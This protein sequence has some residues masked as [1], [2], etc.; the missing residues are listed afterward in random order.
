[1]ART[2]KNKAT[3]YH[4]GLLKARLARLRSSLIDSEKSKGPTTESFETRK[5]GD[6][7]VALVGFPSVGK[8]TLLNKLT[9]T[10]SETASYE[11]TT[12]TCI[13]GV[14]QYNGSN[15]QLLDLPGIIEGASQG[16]GR[17]KQVIATARTA[18]LIL[19]MVDASKGEVHKKLL[20]KELEECGIR[21]NK[22]V[23]HITFKA[24]KTGGLQY[25]AMV[26]QS[27]LSEKL[28]KDILYEQK[29]HNAEVVLRYDATIDDFIDVV[30][31][32]RQYIKCVYVYN[33]IDTISIEE[34]D[35]IA[36]DPY[37]VVLSCEWDLNYDYL[38]A[39]IWEGLDLLRIYTKKRGQQPD[40][41]E[42]IIC[43]NGST[44]ESI[45]NMIHKDMAKNMKYSFVWGKSTKHSPQ[46]V[47]LNHKLSD[48]DVVQIIATVV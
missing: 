48:E 23:P 7:R 36:K 14:I 5:S 27:Q 21:V 2:Q 34:V 16:K 10:K 43:R 29:I 18:D 30:E 47:G 12:L 9:G 33:K 20:E 37:N 32:N 11:F 40:F 19:M 46:R 35:E 17:G 3:E 8:S 38:L 24:K 4:I 39:K 42:P 45:C 26:K 6:A 41:T 25:T 44:I 1:M 22:K 31:G 28:V 13:P 15:I